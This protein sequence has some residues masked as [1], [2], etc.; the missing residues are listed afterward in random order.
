MN[1]FEDAVISEI[2]LSG[3][4]RSDARGIVETNRNQKIIFAGFT[5]GISAKEVAQQI[6]K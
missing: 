6:L 4:S 5:G 1:Q 3:V 2:E